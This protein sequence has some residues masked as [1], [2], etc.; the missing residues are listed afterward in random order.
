VYINAPLPDVA[1]LNATPVAE[2]APLHSFETLTLNLEAQGFVVLPEALPPDV[3][4]ALVDY[5]ATVNA[6]DFHAAAVGRG[7]Q[8]QRNHFVRRDRIH[9]LDER[10]PTL[11]P[12]RAWIESLRIYLNRRLYLG[13]LS[14]ES[15]L[16]H[17]RPGDF[18]RTH[19]DAF[20]G[21]ANRILSLVCY[22]NEEWT[23]GDGGELV[24][25]SQLGPVV[26]KP[27]HR[28][29]VLFLSEEIPH[30][31]KPARRDRFSVTGW[32]RVNASSPDRVD[33]PR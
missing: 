12:W 20:R 5:A 21:E 26:V 33:P 10:N 2:P 27:I 29:L 11:A 19:V 9:W 25:Y 28:T 8:A 23:E 24:L 3:V 17:Y 13:L 22:L 32:F 30:E 7:P 14:F 31:V 6:N 15:H 16:A 4:L 1:D 18:Y